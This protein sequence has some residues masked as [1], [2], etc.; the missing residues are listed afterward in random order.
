MNFFLKET[1]Y[2][3]ELRVGRLIT[4]IA[5]I[6]LIVILVLSCITSVPAGYTGVPVTFGKEAGYTFDSGIHFKNPFRNILYQFQ[7]LRVKP[8]ALLFHLPG[9]IIGV[10]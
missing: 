2:G 9:N 10:S 7:S 3:K 4:V 8:L 5:I 6:S 1:K